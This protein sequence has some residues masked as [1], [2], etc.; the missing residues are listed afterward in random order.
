MNSFG[1]FFKYKKNMIKLW[2]VE[3]SEGRLVKVAAM[4]DE[5]V[6]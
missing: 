1:V 6:E 5:C 3:G 4:V 2:D